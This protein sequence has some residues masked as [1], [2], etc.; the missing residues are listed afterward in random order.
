MKNNT[1]I[2]TYYG[3]QQQP[4][5]NY[6]EAQQLYRLPSMIDIAERSLFAISNS[7]V[8]VII[9]E[10]GAGKSTTMRYAINE[11]PSKHYHPIHIIGG[12]WSFVELLRQCMITLGLFTR[13]NQQTTMLKQIYEMFSHIRADG[14]EPVLFIDESDLFHQNV[15]SQLH[16]LSQQ[17]P[18]DNRILPIIMCGQETLFEKL[19]N[20][21]ARPLFNRVL[22][23]Y[24]LRSMN[25]NECIGYIQ[26]HLTTIAGSSTDI[27]NEQAIIAV[28]QASGG[29]PRNINSICLK[30]L[31]HGMDEKVQT[32]SA[33]VIRKVTEEWWAC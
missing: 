27:F 19:K 13:T 9:G 24:N 1:D 5:A 29:I 3:F 15:F 2:K 4:F 12:A 10:I 22:D 26:H 31:K 30:A 16:L 11:L 23:G 6:L 33:E 20:P 8:F 28:T 17:N 32:I 14:R 21:Y 18:N 7:M 25:Q